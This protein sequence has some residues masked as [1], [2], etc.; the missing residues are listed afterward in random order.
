[1]AY[2]SFSVERDTLVIEQAKGM[3]TM[4]AL[5]SLPDQVAA[6]IL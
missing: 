4:T 5:V 2:I 3:P 6:E 1:M